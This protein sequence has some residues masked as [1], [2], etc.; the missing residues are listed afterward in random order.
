MMPESAL[1]PR[2]TFRVRMAE[3]RS[4]DLSDFPVSVIDEENVPHEG[5]RVPRAI[6]LRFRKYLETAKRH[7]SCSVLVIVGRTDLGSWSR[8]R[9][10]LT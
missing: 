2:R 6:N 1:S 3:T 8:N 9:A 7:Y 5:R 10:N 4:T